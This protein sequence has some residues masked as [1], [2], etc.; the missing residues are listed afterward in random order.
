VAAM[1]IVLRFGT[2]FIASSRVRQQTATMPAIS[3]R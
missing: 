1:K 2:R 3:D